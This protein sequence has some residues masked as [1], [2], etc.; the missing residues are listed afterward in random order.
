MLGFY[1]NFYGRDC[2]L[3]TSIREKSLVLGLDLLEGV[4][5]KLHKRNIIITT[6]EARVVMEAMEPASLEAGGKI[7]A[8]DKSWEI[9]VDD[10]I[11]VNGV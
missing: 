5:K 7:V 4:R 2:F 8:L 6:Y 1:G 9:L 11:I 3:A 10:V